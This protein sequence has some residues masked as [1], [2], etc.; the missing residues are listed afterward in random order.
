MKSKQMNV[1]EHAGSTVMLMV[2]STGASAG[3][4][5]FLSH[6][7]VMA[8]IAFVVSAIGYVF[9][10]APFIK[11]HNDIVEDLDDFDKRIGSNKT[12]DEIAPIAGNLID[13]ALSKKIDGLNANDKAIYDEVNNI[14]KNIKPSGLTDEDI[15]KIVNAVQKLAGNDKDKE[16]QDVLNMV[17]TD[18]EIKK[19]ILSAVDSE[20]KQ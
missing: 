16:V 11:S 18:P 7:T 1:K 6:N 13:D 15:N 3:T 17:K 14:T 19:K 12:V 4:Y 10:I 5:L 9:G 20:I 2:G 8:G